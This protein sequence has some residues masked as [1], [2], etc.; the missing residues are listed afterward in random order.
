MVSSGR[1]FGLCGRGRRGDRSALSVFGH[2][3]RHN[4]GRAAGSLLVVAEI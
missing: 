1:R 3:R 4:H 2:L